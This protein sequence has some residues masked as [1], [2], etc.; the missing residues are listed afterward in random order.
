MAV[1]DPEAL[2][3][4]LIQLSEHAERLSALD[5]RQATHWDETRQRLDALAG[6]AG[7]M[8]RTLTDQADILGGLAQR[9]DRLDP[10]D[11]QETLLYTPSASPRFWQLS[12]TD[13]E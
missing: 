8:K 2:T 11:G 3:A 1:P 9:L 5:S 6:L 7:A 4:A 10:A 12:G 13:R